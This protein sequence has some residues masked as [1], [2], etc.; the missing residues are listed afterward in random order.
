MRSAAC[1]FDSD[2]F[3]ILAFALAKSRKRAKVAN[4]I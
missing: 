1:H 3:D 4:E 2:L